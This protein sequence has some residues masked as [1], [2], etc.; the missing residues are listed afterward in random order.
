MC[1]IYFKIVSQIK[2]T[3][4]CFVFDYLGL[5]EN[6]ILA[7]TISKNGLKKQLDLVSKQKATTKTGLEMDKCVIKK[8]N[9]KR[10]RMKKVI[11]K[12]LLALKSD[13]QRRNLKD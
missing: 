2:S 13:R 7:M 10:R 3:F 12:A 9:L 5:N 8:R 1:V 6:G 4:G 11:L